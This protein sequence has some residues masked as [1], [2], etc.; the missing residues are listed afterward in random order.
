MRKLLPLALIG[1]PALYYLGL[2]AGAATYPGYSHVTNYASELGAA[3]APYPWLFNVSIILAGAAAILAAMLLPNAFRDTGASRLWSVLAAIALGLWGAA[4]VMGGL[5][6]M[7]DDRHGAFGL[8]LVGPLIPLFVLL[9]LRPIEDSRG[10]QVFLAIIFVA[11][12]VMLAI[13]FG[14]GDLVT[15]A[16]VGLYQRLNSGA[17]TPWFAV[18]GLWLLMRKQPIGRA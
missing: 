13:M 5:F 11:S 8:G 2:I 16:N 12:V 9:A 1:I 14:V 18:L 3:D 7:P 6:P 4:M 17:S 10:V 15:R